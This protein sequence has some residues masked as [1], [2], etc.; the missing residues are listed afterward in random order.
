MIEFEEVL[1]L[2]LFLPLAALSGCST[3]S[4]DTER[5]RSRP[6][7]RF[8]VTRPGAS[9]LDGALVVTRMMT[10]GRGEAF[11]GY[12]AEVENRGASSLAFEFRTVWK[13]ASD[14]AL[15]TGEW[16]KFEIAPGE[17]KVIGDETTEFTDARFVKLEVRP[18]S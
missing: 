2:L 18:R 15:G 14:R 11:T 9:F 3:S 8:D 10:P 6:E 7:D 5:G 13:D 16:Q 17:K 4:E 12:D 1:R